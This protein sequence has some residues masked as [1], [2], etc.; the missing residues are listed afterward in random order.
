[1]SDIP[2]RQNPLLQQMP[3]TPSLPDVLTI[4]PTTT[5]AAPTISAASLRHLE[6]QIKDRDRLILER[7]SLE[8]AQIDDY[9]SI[10]NNQRSTNKSS[11]E[12]DSYYLNILNN[13][14]TPLFFTYFICLI[15]LGFFFFMGDS[16][17]TMSLRVFLMVI[18]LGYPFVIVYLED[19]VISWL[20]VFYSYIRFTP[21]GSNPIRDAVSS[22][23]FLYGQRF[24]SLQDIE[25]GLF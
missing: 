17:L 18:F 12:N 5:P 23:P 8:N 7:L 11:I 20:S 16:D 4:P 24:T 19:W 2:L 1:M 10:L 3:V 21:I 14:Y 25:A 9:I 15:I 22:Q 6:R 13:I